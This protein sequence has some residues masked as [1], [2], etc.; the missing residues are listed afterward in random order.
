[1]VVAQRPLL[2]ALLAL[3]AVVDSALASA[4]PDTVADDEA[5]T[6]TSAQFFNAL[7]LLNIT[8]GGRLKAAEPFEKACF[9][10]VQGKPVT[11][12]SSACSA[13]QANYTNPSYRVE[14]FGAYMIVSLRSLPQRFELVV[15][16]TYRLNGRPVK[17][18]LAL[19]GA[20]STPRTPRT[21]SRTLV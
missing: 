14:H 4:L 9:S 17:P 12:D 10:T 6:P 20:C 13:L 8:V 5:F 2:S 7:N 18:R 1:M 21:R 3:T 11:V 16:V 15:D 19:R